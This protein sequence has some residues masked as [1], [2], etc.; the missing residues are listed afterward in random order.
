MH[1]RLYIT[2]ALVLLLTSAN[3]QTGLDKVLSEIERNNKSLISEK[4]YWEMQ[5]LSYKTGLNPDNPKIDYE[6][7]PGRPEGAG[8]Q[9]DFS[10]T[11][12]FD[13]PTSYGKRR[14]VSSQQIVQSDLQY[15][16]F[17]QQLLMDAKRLCIDYAYR[18]SL[19]IELNK[20]LENAN[21]LLDAVNRKTEQGESSILDLNKIKLLQLEIRNQVALNEIDIKT[22]QHR[23]D[24]MNGGTAIDLSQVRYPPLP[25]IPPFETLDS[26]IEA[27][28]PVVKNVKQEKEISKQQVQLAKSITL[29]KFEGGYH[30]QSI[31]GQT[32]QGFHVGMTIP[33]WEN[34]NRVK[35]EQARLAH[36]EFQITEHRTRHYYENKQ[37][38]EQYL[39]WQKT[40]DE[41]QHILNAANNEQLLNKAYNAGELSF[42]EYLMEVRYFYDANEKLKSAERELHRVVSELYKY[43]L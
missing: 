23:L 1:K 21:S 8:T 40:V 17:R 24:E 34:Q 28:D 30:R 10:V 41:Y 20:R 15:S 14:N 11:Q 29:P 38:Y 42:I 3:A 4:Q 16:S 18:Q 7:L 27:N 9:K 12:A 22:L 2:V 5:K 32:Y 39:H 19:Q 33:L 36:A 31:L 37:L 26:L 25:A 6:H 43:S 35:T 13:F